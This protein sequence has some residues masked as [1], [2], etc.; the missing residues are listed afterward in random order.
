M[1]LVVAKIPFE[2]DVVQFK[3][4]QSLKPKTPLGSLP[5]LNVDGKEFVQS[6]AILRYIGK[7]GKLYP[8]DAM[9]AL[10]VDQVIDTVLDFFKSL[11]TYSG[12]DKELLKE[13]RD[14]A[15]KVSAPKFL[16]SLEKMLGRSSDGPYVLGD[17]VSTADLVIASLFTLFSTGFLEFV[18]RHAL[19]EYPRMKKISDTVLEIPE[20][21][22]YHKEHPECAPFAEHSPL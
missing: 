3:D 4:W 21:K 14:K 20:V 19:D 11:F 6:Q 16:G 8:E 22:E 12:G 13:A 1:A 7:L 2:N 5:V 18:P 17:H 9:D 15:F 10:M